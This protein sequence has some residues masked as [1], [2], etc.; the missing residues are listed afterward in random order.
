[1]AIVPSL[2]K[3]FMLRRQSH[4]CQVGKVGKVFD[5][6]TCHGKCNRRSPKKENGNK[7]LQKKA[8]FLKEF[9]SLLDIW[10]E[11]SSWSLLPSTDWF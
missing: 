10:D 9:W 7:E 5:V 11:G 4:Q 8:Y 2:G 3:V 6:I 1:M